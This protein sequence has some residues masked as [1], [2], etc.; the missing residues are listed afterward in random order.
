VNENGKNDGVNEDD[1]SI[2]IDPEL[3]K[4]LEEAAQAVPE[5]AGGD[6]SE[7]LDLEETVDAAPEDE[8]ARLRD[9]LLGAN[10]R[11]LRLQ[12]DFEN[13]RKRAAREHQESL[14]YGAQNLVKDLL[15]VVDNLD[16]AID[17][18]QQSEGGDL[19]GLLQG[20]ALVQREFI[21]VLE[22]HHVVGI[23]ALGQLF[24]PALH[25]A[26]AQIPDET[27]DP[28]T[29]IDVMQKGYQLRDRLIRPARVTVAKRPDG[30]DEG[31][32][33]ETTD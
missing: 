21:G 29:V 8:V 3:E 19:Q 7:D 1:L 12:A 18:A 4:A 16:R 28:N 31:G 33:G 15:S 22:K 11:L 24:N 2:A 13:Y 10:D 17:H 30:T 32:Q 9:Q 5:A 25:E 14:Q 20:V 27:V 26:M 23:D 6:D